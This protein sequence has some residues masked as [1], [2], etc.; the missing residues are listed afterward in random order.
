VADELLGD[1]ARNT[2][3]LEP[4]HCAAPKVVRD[5]PLKDEI[6]ALQDVVDPLTWS[7]IDGVRKVGNIGA[8]M[9]KDINV[10]VD[11]DPGE[12]V[13]LVRLIEVLVDDW[14]VARDRRQQALTAVVGLADAKDAQ[15]RGEPGPVPEQGVS[16]VDPEA[17]NA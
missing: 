8:H 2:R 15:R 13:R 17:P 12:A 4:T 9:E 14:Y 5:L 16:A 11:V 6:D 3:A 1:G 10:I 7:G